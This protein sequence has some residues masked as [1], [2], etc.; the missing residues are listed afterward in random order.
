MAV[1]IYSFPPFADKSADK[2]ILGSIPGE[3]SLR[4]QQYYAHPRNMFWKIMGAIFDF[5]PAIPYE[6]RIAMLLE[7][8]I[9]LWD[10]VHNCHRPGSMDSDIRREA[11]NDF[12][13]FFK[14]YPCI[15]KIFF[16]GQTA[17]RLFMKHARTMK[18]PE[19]EFHVMPSTSPAN[20]A[21]S[22][23]AKVEAWRRLKLP[24]QLKPGR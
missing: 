21:V 11:P 18:L 12:E 22:F 8:R 20:A 16:N 10:T 2:L 13:T 23:A 24:D 19:L 6:A 9:A 17:H 3:E 14:T 15:T 5:D 7:N 1:K 4:Q